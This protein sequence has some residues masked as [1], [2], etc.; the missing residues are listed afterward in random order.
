MLILR[1][2]FT[3][4]A[5]VATLA[6]FALPS[7]ASANPGTGPELVQRSGRLVVLHAD[8][9]D[10][11]A[12]R[13]WMLVNGSERLPVRAPEVWIDP[14]SRVRLEGTIEAGQ[15]VL[16]DS[17]TAV[18]QPRRGC[19]R[20][21]AAAPSMHDTAII[22]ATF[23]G[24]AD[25]RSGL[26]DIA[27][28]TSM[29]FGDPL[30][31]PSSLNSYYLEQ[32]YGQLGF[33]GAVFNPVIPGS[34]TSLRRGEPE[35]PVPAW[36][37]AAEAAIPGFSE[38]GY[39]HVVLAFP[40]VTACGLNG[41]SGVAEVGG[42]HVWVNGDFSVRV[43]AHE[44]GHNLGLRH[45]GGL[46]CTSGGSPSPM[47]TC[48]AADQYGDPFD[49]MGRSDSGGGFHSVRQMSMQHKLKLGLLPPSAAKVVGAPGTY[50][51]APMETLT[52][53][54][55]RLLH[56]Q[57]RRRQLLRR[58]PLSD[59]LLRQPAA[60][61]AG[62]SHPHRA[63]RDRGRERVPTRRSSTCTRRR[64]NLWTDAAMDVAQLF[65]DPLTGISIQNVGQDASGAT[66]QIQAPRDLVPPSA[67]TGLTAI[68]SGTT[69]V[70]HWAP[71]SD[72][73]QVDSYR[74]HARRRRHRRH[75]GDGLRRRRPRA[76]HQGRLRGGGR[77]CRRQRRPGSR[78]SLTMPDAI[79]PGAP[80]EAD[81]QA[82]EERRR[83][84]GLGG[85]HRQ[86]RGQRLSRAAQRHG[87]RDRQRARVRRQG[88][89][90][91]QRLDRDVLG[92]RARSRGQLRRGCEGQ[93]VARGAAAQ[94]QPPRI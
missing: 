60:P 88:A 37:S 31:T 91:R 18:T 27:T 73:F 44:L 39:E 2:R 51:I 25:D 74:H 61:A 65:N 1:K 21:V 3:L 82:P 33:R 11:T 40:T 12:T 41:V 29:A 45:A 86:R 36:L 67:T 43:L 47:G 66:L 80:P 72:D 5:W 70:L 22:L 9:S 34:A 83:Q 78:A 4:A 90:A 17:Q 85:G 59:R 28:A 56:S 81:R 77:R 19:R 38:A 57:A 7:L 89:Q 63:A 13:Q 76:R 46:T 32:S 20:A 52:G 53:R 94:A 26:P 92:G 79:A 64:V 8:R 49:A 10:G 16:S 6:L 93:A 35:R 84:P 23:S 75:A 87:D 71:A 14:G 54:R 69:A 15:L 55:R 68:A 58:V 42:K 62:R 30:S 24:G 48:S 50:R